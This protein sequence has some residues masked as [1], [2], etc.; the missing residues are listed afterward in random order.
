MLIGWLSL[1]ASY[2]QIGMGGTPDPSAVLDLRSPANNKGLLVPRLTTQQRRGI[3][4]PAAGLLVF[5]LDKS[6]LYINDGQNW[7]PL[8]L[9]NANAL[10]PINRTAN[11]GAA[12]DGFGYHVAI[13]G[14]YAV[15]GTP[16]D[17]GNRGA[18]YVFSRT[19]GWV[20]QTKLLAPDGVAGDLF[21]FNVAI[22]GDYAMVGAWA[23]DGSRGSVYVFRRDGTNWVYQSKLTGSGSIAADRFGGTVSLNGDYAVVGAPGTNSFQG[24]AYVFVRSGN[25]WV[26]QAQL[27]ASDGAPN[28]W[29]GQSVSLSGNSAL[30]G[31]PNADINGEVDRGAAYVFVRSGNLWTRQT[32]LTA[33]TGGGAGD[34]FAQ[35]V[36]ISGDHALIGAPFDF[37]D[38][39]AFRTGSAYIFQRTGTSWAEQA[40]L[41]AP[42]WIDDL[43][44]YS[45]SLSG[46]YAIVG[47]YQFDLS[48][49][50]DQ[51]AAFL[52]RRNGA[53]WPLLRRV[54]DG[55]P[56]P[57]TRNGVAVGIHNGTF[58]IGGYGFENYKGKVSFGTVD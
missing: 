7:V 33:L 25:D 17:D 26:Q 18:A 2:A 39:G 37:F 11:D 38:G 34:A 51:G 47:A 36:S 48:G 12:N 50:S 54:T 56:I 27:S 1:T 3:Q 15:I 45:V 6:T 5:D 30:V 23:D 29:F 46:D 41:G 4:S 22:S 14:D 24:A 58:V 9:T 21:G 10:Q 8:A 20:Q 40:Y 13:S 52:F 55:S 42:A 16:N 44:G 28:D 57:N 35:S 19:N 32:R 43:F 53:A 31:A 49:G